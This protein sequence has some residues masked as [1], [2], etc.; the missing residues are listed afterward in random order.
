MQ[1]EK[2]IDR[3]LSAGPVRIVS[4]TS[5]IIPEVR[6]IHSEA[7]T[8]YMNTRLGTSYMEA[9]LA[10]F[11]TAEHAIALVAVDCK[12]NVIGYV[13]GAPIDYGPRMNRDLVRAAAVSILSRPWLF[14]SRPFWMII[15]ARVRSLL[16]LASARKRRFEFPEPAMSLVA[17]GVAQSARGK[18]VGLCLLRA[19]ED[20]ARELRIRSL[21]LTVYANNV[22]ARKLYENS[23]WRP[24]QHEDAENNVVGYVRILTD[25]DQCVFPSA[26]QK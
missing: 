18:K 12:E 13:L 22:V 7:F 8:G 9:F 3:F 19:F 21:Q 17:I 4:M 20:K 26:A 5:D 15:A 14:L 25:E 6:N 10:W 23:H 1:T 16:G 2:H 24:L 11:L